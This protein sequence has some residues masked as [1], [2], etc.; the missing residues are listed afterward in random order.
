M[1][2][3]AFFLAVAVSLGTIS[4]LPAEEPASAPDPIA[5]QWIWKGELGVTIYADGTAKQ[6]GQGSAEWRLLH[7]NKTV[8]RKYE[9]IWNRPKGKRFIEILVLSTDY[10]R[11]DGADQKGARVWGERIK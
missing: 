3:L 8:E 10:Q 7:N 6:P 4:P 1:N 2:R 9:F 5:G 11:L